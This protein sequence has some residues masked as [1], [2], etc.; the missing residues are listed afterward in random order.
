LSGDTVQAGVIDNVRWMASRETSLN[1][2]DLFAFRD[3]A[4][5]DPR[6]VVGQTPTT[7][8]PAPA[9]IILTEGARCARASPS[10]RP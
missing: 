6:S 9:A 8:I 10:T 5:L 3:P 2:H 1:R 7:P 4:K